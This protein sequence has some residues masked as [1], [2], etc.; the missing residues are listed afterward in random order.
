MNQLIIDDMPELYAK[1]KPYIEYLEGLGFYSS[2]TDFK[3]FKSGG[4]KNYEYFNCWN[5]NRPDVNSKDG[6]CTDWVV[7]LA[8]YTKEPKVEV[9][10]YKIVKAPK[11]Y[12]GGDTNAYPYIIQNQNEQ[13]HYDSKIVD[14]LKDFKKEIGKYLKL[15]K[16]Y[17][18]RV[19]N[20]DLEKDFTQHYCKILQW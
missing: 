10:T 17:Q 15:I 11:Y 1:L 12:F 16:I 20:H 4:E 2:I 3:H 13:G 19:K 8:S 5:Y 9:Y 6:F 18:E 7:D 14:N